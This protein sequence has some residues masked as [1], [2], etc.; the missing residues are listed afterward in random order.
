[1]KHCQLKKLLD[2]NIQPLNS[3]YLYKPDTGRPASSWPP[4]PRPA[5]PASVRARLLSITFISV[6]WYDI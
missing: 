4:A 2:P 1:M 3:N 6:H 5:E